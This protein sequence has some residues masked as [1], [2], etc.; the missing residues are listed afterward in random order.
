MRTK[1][2]RA[3]E[4]A[5]ANFTPESVPSSRTILRWIRQ[6]KIDGVIMQNNAYVFE[7]SRLFSEAKGTPKGVS[8]PPVARKEAVAAMLEEWGMRH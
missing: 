3:S 6:G 2:M 7:D 8:P 5:K 1:M 4:W